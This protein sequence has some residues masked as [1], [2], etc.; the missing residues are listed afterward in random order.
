MTASERNGEGETRSA[1]PSLSKPSRKAESLAGRLERDAEAYREAGYQAV[2]EALTNAAVLIRQQIEQIG[3][4][5]KVAA[6]GLTTLDLLIG[7]NEAN[8]AIRKD[9]ARITELEGALRDLADEANRLGPQLPYNA[10]TADI[11]AAIDRARA[12]LQARAV[13]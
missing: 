11:A 3:R 9:R 6:N 10:P 13:A 2:P 12:I 5:N 7:W 8:K 1:S 4:L